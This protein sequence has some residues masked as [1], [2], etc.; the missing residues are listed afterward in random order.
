MQAIISFQLSNGSYPDVGMDI[1]L[2]MMGLKTEQGY[3]RRANTYHRPYRAEFFNGH[4]FS[5]KPY[6][7]VYGGKV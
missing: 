6:R 7:T 1:R 2:P 5:G 3:I 4:L